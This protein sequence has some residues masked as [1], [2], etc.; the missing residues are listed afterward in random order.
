MKTKQPFAFIAL[1]FTFFL[2]E[3]SG[4]LSLDE[5]VSKIQGEHGIV[6]N[7][8]DSPTPP[9]HLT[10]QHYEIADPGI[11]TDPRYDPR[12]S[13]FVSTKILQIAHNITMQ[14]RDVPVKSSIVA[15]VSIAGALALLLLGASGQ[16]FNEIMHL[17]GFDQS[18]TLLSNPYK[19]HE[20]FGLLIEDLLS[21]LPN[22]SRPRPL[23]PWKYMTHTR[24]RS[25]NK[26]NSTT[27]SQYHFISVA[28]ALFTQ[29]QFSLRPDYKTAV[30]DIYRSELIPLDFRGNIEGSKKF[31]ND[32]VNYKTHGKITEIVGPELNT[33]T[34]MIIVS[35]L[36]F[37]ALWEQSFIDGATNRKNFYPNGL[38]AAPITV[39]MMAHGGVFP[40][41][42]A[43]EYDC[44][45]L[46]FPYR[47]NQTT[48]YIILPNNS[49]RQRLREIQTFLTPEKIE[50]MISKMQLKTTIILFPKL[51]I[52]NTVDL[53]P[54]FGRMGFTSVF[55]PGQSDLSLISS[56][57]VR[58]FSN[59][60]K[61]AGSFVHPETH[62]DPKIPVFQP[63][64]RFSTAAASP[65]RGSLENEL[66][67]SRFGSED[68]TDE[69]KEMQSDQAQPSDQDAS[70][71]SESQSDAKRRK[72]AVTYKVESGFH[73]DTPSLRYKDFVLSKRIIKQKSEKKISRGRRQV[74][75]LS[76]S[77]RRLDSL[78][79]SQNLVNPGLFADAIVHKID[80]T[81]NEEG[82][83]GGAATAVY[84]TRTGTDVVFRVETPF[85][86]LVRHDATKIP[87]FYGPVYEPSA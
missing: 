13:E 35:S 63:G 59:F 73:K 48:M 85:I 50:D 6:F 66:V 49:S 43:K 65:V 58:T 69:M 9:P 5:M 78:R 17:C 77:L 57:I 1:L 70:P 11:P 45:I 38:N 26:S 62:M 12:I 72:R 53:K 18:P 23:S 20:E 15:P 16:T 55:N 76:D 42:D 27:P 10:H 32:W 87:L 4:Q 8:A 2:L 67:F 71:P 28:N 44:R 68:I 60:K 40:F 79:N 3:A 81:V 84:L 83:E 22:Q 82:T 24:R 31:I 34:N 74:V 64:D 54:V 47:G 51:H 41:Y 46:G 14:Y 7:S 25:F 21:D 80:L 30:E 61:P 56:G 29:K 33:E 37:K 36:Y 19:I 52:Q 39:D 75:N 86:L